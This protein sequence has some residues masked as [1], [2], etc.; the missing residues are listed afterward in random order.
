M[1]A[2]SE[3]TF[4]ASCDQDMRRVLPVNDLHELLDDK[5]VSAGGS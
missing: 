4:G 3:T 2:D 1:L 5:S